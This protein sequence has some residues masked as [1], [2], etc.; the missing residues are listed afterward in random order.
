MLIPD[1]ATILIPIHTLHNDS[2]EYENP[3]TYDPDRFLGHPKLVPDYATSAGY[4]GSD[5]YGYGARWR[6]CVDMHLAERTRWRVIEAVLWT[7]EIRVDD[8]L[9]VGT[10]AFKSGF[11]NTPHPFKAELVP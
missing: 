7:L 6:V 8:E 4:E 9:S 2:S 1:R 10:D 3:A 5:H 11:F